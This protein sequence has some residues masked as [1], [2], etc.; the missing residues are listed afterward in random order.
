MNLCKISQ[1]LKGGPRCTL[2]SLCMTNLYWF[3]Q[4]MPCAR[5]SLDGPIYFLPFC[6]FRGYKSQKRDLPF[7]R[8]LVLEEEGLI[9]KGVTR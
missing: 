6:L 8:I 1:V 4:P 9:V 2:V 5:G 3:N 7:T